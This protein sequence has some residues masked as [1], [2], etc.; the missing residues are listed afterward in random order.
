MRRGQGTTPSNPKM[1]VHLG[2]NTTNENVVLIDTFQQLQVEMM[3]L[4]I[5][6]DKLRL[7]QERI[8]KILSD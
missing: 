8:L 6:N 1:W 2:E 7:E 3:N 5:D 4:H